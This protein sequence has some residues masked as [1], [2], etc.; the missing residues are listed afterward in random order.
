MCQGGCPSWT[1]FWKAGTPHSG[2]SQ[3]HRDLR[4]QAQVY[5]CPWVQTPQGSEVQAP[6]GTGTQGHR[7]PGIQVPRGTGVQGTGT[8][9]HRHPG[10]QV[11]GGRGVQEY[12]CLR[13][14]WCPRGQAPMDIGCQGTG[15][16]GTGTD[17]YLL[18]MTLCRSPATL[19]TSALFSVPA[20]SAP[21][22]LGLL[23][24]CSAW[25]P[26]SQES[27]DTEDGKCHLSGACAH[28]PCAECHLT[29]AVSLSLS[30][31]LQGGSTVVIKQV[32]R[33]LGPGFRNSATASTA[34]DGQ[35][36]NSAPSIGL[37]PTL[38]ALQPTR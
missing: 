11:P 32:G 34:G 29:S 33:E 15:A 25:K 37:L 7:H 38:T 17:I 31:A 3:G 24:M 1:A 2:A 26:R 4:A 18:F 35:N 16:R 21:A 13:K 36:W 27:G 9:G 23:L 6:G 12:R 20:S 14:C 19:E 22:P 28:W 8:W 30:P 10:I 5:R